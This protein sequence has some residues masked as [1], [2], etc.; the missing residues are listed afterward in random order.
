M[1]LRKYRLIYLLIFDL[2]SEYVKETHYEA[3]LFINVICDFVLLLSLW[4]T[5]QMQQVPDPPAQ[6]HCASFFFA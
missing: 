2:F 1:G 4:L 6:H 3:S 5:V